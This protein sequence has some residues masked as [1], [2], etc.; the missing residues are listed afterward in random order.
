MQVKRSGRND[1]GLDGLHI[2]L[3]GCDA[4]IALAGA[5]LAVAQIHALTLQG[6]AAGG[7]VGALCHQRE[8]GTDL[9]VTRCRHGATALERLGLQLNLAVTEDLGSVGGLGLIAQQFLGS[10]AQA[11]CACMPNFPAIVEEVGSLECQMTAVAL[12]LAAGVVQV[13]SQANGQ[14]VTAL[15]GDAASYVA[16]GL[17]LYAQGLGLYLRCV[18]APGL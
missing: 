10:D 17:R 6:H 2:T 15:L 1:F 14:V 9:Q 11:A 16:H 4:Q 12:Q 3:S 18:S 13:T 8:L 5:G 7:N